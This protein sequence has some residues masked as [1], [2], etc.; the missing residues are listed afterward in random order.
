MTK[1]YVLFFDHDYGDREDW[2]TFYTPCEVFADAATRDA[3]EKYLKVIDGD[4]HFH[5]LDLDLHTTFN[6]PMT[7]K[8]L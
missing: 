3:R 1:V 7:E 5:T 4:L 8:D 2:N 6:F